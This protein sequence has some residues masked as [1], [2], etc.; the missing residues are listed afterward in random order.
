MGHLTCTIVRI[1]NGDNG[2][3]DM[4]TN[5]SLGIAAFA[6]GVHFVPITQEDFPPPAELN[7]DYP[8]DNHHRYPL[9]YRGRARARV[10]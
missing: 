1:Y 7:S 2:V 6:E 10:T 8:R 9:G 4:L 3:D 5:Q